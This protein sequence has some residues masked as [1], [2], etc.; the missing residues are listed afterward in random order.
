MIQPVRLKL[1][2]KSG[3]NLQRVSLETNGLEAKVVARP[4]RWGN[5]WTIEYNGRWKVRGF[6]TPIG[7][8]VCGNEEGARLVAVDLFRKNSAP[9]LDVSLLRGKNLA[10]WCAP[11]AP[12]HADVLL[13]IANG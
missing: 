6:G 10:C 7:G 5:P 11:G 13:E 4:S 1:S 12:C 3:F 9:A 2:R 8:L